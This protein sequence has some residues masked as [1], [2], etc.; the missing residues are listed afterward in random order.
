MSDQRCI[1]FSLK[2]R[3]QTMDKDSGGKG[4]SPSWSIGR[5]SDKRLREHLEET[6]LIDEL[7]WVCPA[8]SLKATVRSTR[9]NVVETCDCSMS[10]RRQARASKYWWNDKRW[11]PY[12]VNAS[13]RSGNSPARRDMLC[14][15]RH[16]KGQMHRRRTKESG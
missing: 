9:Q 12:A 16:G 11:L 8:G 2:Q 1:E 7:G 3:R 14:C 15:M 5:L 4:R 10:R 13:Q 6:R